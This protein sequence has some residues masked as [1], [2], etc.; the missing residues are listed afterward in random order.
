VGEPDNCVDI[1]KKNKENWTT[2]EETDEQKKVYKK[3]EKNAF[4]AKVRGVEF[5]ANKEE[6]KIIN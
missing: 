4:M 3:M 6:G 1:M 2:Y 5:K